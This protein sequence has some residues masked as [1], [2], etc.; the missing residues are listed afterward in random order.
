MAAPRSRPPALAWVF[1]AALP[2]TAQHQ[3]VTPLEAGRVI[4]RHLERGAEHRYTIA[5]GAGEYA[6]VIVEQRGVDVIAQARGPDDG[7][8]ADFEDE[9]RN[10]GQEQVEIVADVPGTYSIAIRAAPGIV[11]AGAYTIS[12]AGQRAATDSDRAI[13]ESRRLRTSAARLDD[14]GRFDAARSLLERALAITEAE[15]GAGDLQTAAV[16]AQ[17]AAVYR[18]L[19]DDARSEALFERALAIMDVSLGPDHPTTAVVRSRLGQLYQKT[20]QRAK[21]EPLLRQALD[22]IERT[23]GTENRWFVSALMTLANLHGD[24]GDHE[25][26]EEID[27]RALAIMER[28]EDTDSSLYAALLNNLGEIYRAKRDYAQA[29]ELYQRSLAIGAGLLGEDSYFIATALQNLGIVARE[30]KD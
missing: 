8:I 10:S 28:I 15:R 21:A 5:L 14:E 22:V 13:Q 19:P 9:I 18:K 24:A 3:D 11:A 12:L 17:L 20:G 23:L 25:Q 4:E 29:E 30:R 16:A 27:R 7:A 1:Q 26:E 2:L 6:R